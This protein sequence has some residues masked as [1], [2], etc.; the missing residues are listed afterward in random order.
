M[1]DT[2]L[3]LGKI[4][5]VLRRVDQKSDSSVLFFTAYMIAGDVYDQTIIGRIR[6]IVEFPAGFWISTP[7]GLKIASPNILKCRVK[8]AGSICKRS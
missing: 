4:A 1:P 6:Q 5:L 7:R 3:S 2:N 8:A